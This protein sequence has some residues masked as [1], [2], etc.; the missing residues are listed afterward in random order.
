[1]TTASTAASRNA[2]KHNCTSKLL[3]LPTEST[4][5][6]AT[7]HASL[8][9]EYQPSTEMQN[10]TV[11]EAARAVWELRRINRE[12]D[13]TQKKL[14]GQQPNMSDWTPPQH[15]EYERMLRYRTRAERTHTRSLKS[16]EYLRTL[17][18]RAEQRAFWESVQLAKLD[19]S[20]RRLQQAAQRFQP[21]PSQPLSEA[22]TLKRAS[23][24]RQ[25]APHSLHPVLPTAANAQRL[26]AS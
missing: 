3:I 5:E 22:S 1:M 18:I 13:K 17:R 23:V 8:I 15:A 10:Q 19:I 20:E 16:L 14:Y 11:D 9:A 26:R 24:E 7:L 6:F 4:E 21:V 12:F 2:A 25:A